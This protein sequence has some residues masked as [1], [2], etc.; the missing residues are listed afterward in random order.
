VH[1]VNHRVPEVGDPGHT[2]KPAETKPDEVR[3]RYRVRAPYHPYILLSDDSQ[4]FY[5]CCRKPAD[6]P[7]RQC[8]KAG[9]FT[10]EAKVSGAVQGKRASHHCA[11]TLDNWAGILCL[12][13]I[14]SPG[15]GSKY[16]W[17]PIVLGQKS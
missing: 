5:Y 1:L 14:V 7:V 2:A 12:D 16:E 11:F 13:G 8:E 10:P 9:V 4:A 3:R 17:L 6:P 15:V